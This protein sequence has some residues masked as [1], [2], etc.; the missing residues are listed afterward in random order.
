MR[1]RA[2][3]PGTFDPITYGHADIVRRAAQLFSEVIIAIAAHPSKTKI[4]LFSLEEREFLAR[5]ALANMPNVTVLSFNGLLLDFMTQYQAQVI[6]R[7][8][9]A[10]SDFDYEFQLAGI[11]RTLMP[12]VETVFLA[13]STQYTYISSTLVKEIAILGGPVDAFVH[14]QVVAAFIDKFTVLKRAECDKI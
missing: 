12:R 2:V 13:P 11:N 3:Y 9:R 8:L 10:V 14:P 7:G 6:V 1:V 4:P 5:T